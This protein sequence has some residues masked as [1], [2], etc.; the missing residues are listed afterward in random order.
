[1]LSRSVSGYEI[2][3]WKGCREEGEDGANDFYFSS[4][5]WNRALRA[6]PKW[7]PAWLNV[8]KNGR[9]LPPNLTGIFLYKK[10][11]ERKVMNPIFQHRIIRSF[12]RGWIVAAILH[13]LLF[14]SGSILGFK[15]GD[16]FFPLFATYLHR[17]RLVQYLYAYLNIEPRCIYGRNDFF[18]SCSLLDSCEIFSFTAR[19]TLH[20]SWINAVLI[21]RSRNGRAEC[22]V[23]LLFEV[24]KEQVSLGSCCYKSKCDAPSSNSFIYLFK[25]GDIY[26]RL[27]F[28]NY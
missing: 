5:S 11:R 14:V 2:E 27:T 23:T 4:S 10:K 21:L 17:S 12:P 1:M 25:K 28:F 26:L 16:I 9:A 3:G 7:L 13:D 18:S 24:R 6:A 20:R 15:K 19:W 22:L 8:V